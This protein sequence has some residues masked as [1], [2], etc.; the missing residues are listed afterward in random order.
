MRAF[1]R[2]A[3]CALL[4]LAAAQSSFARV[5]I[6]EDAIETSADKV[7]LPGSTDGTLVIA[8]CEQC[9]PTTLQA[10]AAT[11]YRIGKEKVS[12]Q[13]FAAFLRSNPY[14]AVGVTYDKNTRRVI[15]IRA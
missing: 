5:P 7:T 8:R 13:E 3:V 10:G 6:T 2:I 14:A 1:I 12:L 4:A 9:P 15:R 11:E